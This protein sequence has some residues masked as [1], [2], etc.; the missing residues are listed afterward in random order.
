M[1]K[2]APLI[3]HK[4]KERRCR[5]GGGG[6]GNN[7]L[8]KTKAQP[9]G[10]RQIIAREG[11]RSDQIG[12]AV[13]TGKAYSLDRQDTAC[14]EEPRGGKSEKSRRG[15]EATCHLSRTYRISVEETAI[16]EDRGVSPGCTRDTRVFV[17]VVERGSICAPLSPNGK[18]LLQ[19]RSTAESV[20]KASS[21]RLVCSGER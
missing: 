1:V 5:L 6:N 20:W 14:R 9:K 13:E 8:E 18:E 2:I 17:V 12:R 4:Q 11:S 15:C 3:Q 7:G 10:R 16:G 21:L 19:A